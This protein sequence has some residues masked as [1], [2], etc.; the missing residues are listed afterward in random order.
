[1][2]PSGVRVIGFPMDKIG[3]VNDFQQSLYR[4]GYGKYETPKP[5]D[6]PKLTKQEKAEQEEDARIVHEIAKR[7]EGPPSFKPFLPADQYRRLVPPRPGVDPSTWNGMIV[8]TGVVGIHKAHDNQL[9][10]RSPVMY[11]VP[12]TLTVVEVQSGG[13]LADSKNAKSLPLWVVDDSRTKVYEYDKGTVYLPFEALQNA[14]GMKGG[15]EYTDETGKHAEPGRTSFIHIKVKEGASL[16]G[17]RDQVKD[18]VNQVLDDKGEIPLH[19]PVAKTW[20]ENSAVFINAVEN[21]KMLLLILFGIISVVAIFLI[22]CIFYMIVAEK[23]KDIGIVKSVGATSTG[24]AGI[25]LGYGLA[26]GVVGGGMGL[27]TGYLIVHNIN[28]LH[29]WLGKALN[30]TIWNPEVYLFDTI[31]N[32]MDPVEVTVIVAVAVIASVLG[33]LVPAIR[34]ARM[35]PIEALRWE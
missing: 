35:H 13:V 33:A 5:I 2:D 10:N 30:V 24:V 9:I 1:L 17:V 29:A 14:L 8:G 7:T 3:K 26:I 16:A 11:R 32:R 4:Q 31:P 23:T 6:D 28:E 25:F 12:A 21:E 34:A 22:F 19:R 27:L 20:E 18:V 15:K